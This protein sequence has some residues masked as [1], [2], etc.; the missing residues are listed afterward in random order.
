MRG[1]Y[2]PCQREQAAGQRNRIFPRTGAKWQTPP[3]RTFSSGKSPACRSQRFYKLA[4]LA[5]GLELAFDD[6]GQE[7]EIHDAPRVLDL[8]HFILFEKVSKLGQREFG[9]DHLQSINGIDLRVI[10]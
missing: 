4:R 8:L 2:L 3:S 10:E 9:I 7:L 6:P 1:L 5:R